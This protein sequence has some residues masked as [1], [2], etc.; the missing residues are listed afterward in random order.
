MCLRQ[1]GVG[2]L[3]IARNVVAYPCRHFA[4]DRR[5]ECTVIGMTKETAVQLQRLYLRAIEALAESLP[6]SQSSLPD[7]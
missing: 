3:T 7:G 6:L 2:R 4:Q 1:T 5:H